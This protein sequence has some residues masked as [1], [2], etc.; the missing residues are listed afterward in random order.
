MQCYQRLRAPGSR[1]ELD[2]EGL[3]IEDFHDSAEIAATKPDVG[4]VTRE[5][6]RIEKL[7]HHSPG[8]AV[9]NVGCSEPGRS[10]QTVVKRRAR[11]DGPLRIPLT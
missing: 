6:D 9:I 7:E 3:V 2:L 10:N 1:D 4:D 8:N 11:P 5:C